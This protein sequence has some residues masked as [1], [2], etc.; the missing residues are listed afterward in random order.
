MFTRHLNYNASFG[1]HGY[2]AA[3][4]LALQARRRLQPEAGEPNR[5]EGERLLREAVRTAEA[6]IAEVEADQQWAAYAASVTK[7]M[8]LE[9]ARWQRL[10]ADVD[11]A[12]APAPAMAVA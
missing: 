9:V 12:A 8:R 2:A 5:L 1:H 11:A 10:L 7:H 3:A 4:A 6:A